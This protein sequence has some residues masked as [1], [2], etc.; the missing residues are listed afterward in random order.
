MTSSP[1]YLL[2]F[3]GSRD[4]RSHSAVDRLARLVRER[5]S[6]P[7]AGRDPKTALD[8]PISPIPLNELALPIESRHPW[9]THT[10]TGHRLLTS[11][12]EPSPSIEKRDRSIE[13]RDRREKSRVAMASTPIVGT[14]CLE[15]GPR[16]LHE[17]IYQFSQRVKAAGGAHVKVL[18]LFLLPG[19]HVME[20]IPREMALARQILNT[21]LDITLCPY[22]GSHFGLRKLL[23]DRMAEVPTAARLLIAHGSQR[24]GGNKPIEE[25]AKQLGG[26][27]A[28]WSVYPD[29]ETQIIHLMQK[30]HHQL[31]ILPYFLFP[32]GITDAITQFTEELAERFP[33]V[34]FRLM[35]PLG[36]TPELADVVVDLSKEEGTCHWGVE[37]A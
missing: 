23:I 7:L 33:R 19:V 13:E 14:A 29:L 1:A 32:G 10:Q 22:L 20:D 26:I 35:P 30:G 12:T 2:V 5:L 28:Y 18:P 24:P 37:R 16:P 6:Q 17:Q 34:N 25:I 21:S 8:E 15:L 11:P 4:S 36:A 31:A 27:A 9:S 3:H